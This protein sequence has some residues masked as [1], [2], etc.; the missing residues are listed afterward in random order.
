MTIAQKVK[1]LGVGQFFNSLRVTKIYMKKLPQY[2]QNRNGQDIIIINPQN[3]VNDYYNQPLVV[4]PI[5]DYLAQL[6][7]MK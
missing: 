1:S 7:S 4:I 2:L 3:D 5:S 6:R